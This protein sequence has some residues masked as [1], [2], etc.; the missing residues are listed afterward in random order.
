MIFMNTTCDEDR[1][2]RMQVQ[3]KLIGTRPQSPIL[4]AFTNTTY[5]E[6]RQ[7]TFVL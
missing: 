5:D 2:I 7:F 6:D 3:H 1:L 4:I